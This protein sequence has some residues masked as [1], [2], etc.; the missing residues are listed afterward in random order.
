MTI[1]F[2][3]YILILFHSSIF[4]ACHSP[5]YIAVDGTY[6]N[7]SAQGMC[8]AGDKAYLM[9]N[10]GVCRV[11]DLKRQRVKS[12]FLLNSYSKSNHVNSASWYN[13]V[14]YV[15]EC[16][17]PCRCFVEKIY[18]DT[19]SVIVQT[20]EVNRNKENSIAHDWV[21]DGKTQSLYTVSNLKHFYLKEKRGVHR[22]TRYR[23][24]AL[25]DGS[26]ITLTDADVIES[27][28]VEFPNLLQG[29]C[30]KGKYLYLPTGLH[31]GNEE[32]LD[33]ERTLIIINLRKH[34]IEGK[35]DIGTIMSNEPEDC[36]FYK[37]RLLLFC[38]QSG[39]IYEIPTK[40]Y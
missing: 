33:S 3:W 22:I 19:C 4:Y 10:T 35:I 24:P 7:L 29:A 27:F 5:A 31:K 21:V 34:M 12:E 30:I 38:G 11:F 18:G 14:I 15:S 26:N 16:A 28:D 20:I 13:G 2:K 23:L 37:G 40:I 9:N 25:E 32:R 39:G 1:N 8:I 6:K 17:S 36:D